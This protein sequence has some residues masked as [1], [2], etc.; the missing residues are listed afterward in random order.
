M[1]ILGIIILCIVIF[2]ILAEIWVRMVIDPWLKE[3]D[4]DNL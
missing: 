2:I 1:K 3:N 4:P